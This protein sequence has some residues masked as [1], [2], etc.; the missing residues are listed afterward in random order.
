[1]RTGM[2]CAFAFM[3]LVMIAG[4]TSVSSA[5]QQQYVRGNIVFVLPATTELDGTAG[6]KFQWI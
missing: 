6:H 4:I 5:Q 2:R 1:M 3:F